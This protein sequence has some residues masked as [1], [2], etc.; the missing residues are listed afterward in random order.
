MAFSAEPFN[1][2]R[3]IIIRMVGFDLLLCRAHTTWLPLEVSSLNKDMRICTTVCF[4]A[5]LCCERFFMLSLPL[6]TTV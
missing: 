3:I 4:V 6:C 1:K 5:L 2:P